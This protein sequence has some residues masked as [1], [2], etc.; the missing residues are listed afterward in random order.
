M[1]VVR[2]WNQTLPND[3]V[4][5][6][7]STKLRKANPLT[8]WCNRQQTH[9]QFGAIDRDH[10][11]WEITHIWN[12]KCNIFFVNW[13]VSRSPGLRLDQEIE[14]P[15]WE[16]IPAFWRMSQDRSWDQS[17]DGPQTRSWERY[18]GLFSGTLS[19]CNIQCACVMT[20]VL[21]V[22][23][24]SYYRVQVPPFSTADTADRVG[25]RNS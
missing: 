12:I 24:A 17:R 21:S 18:R 25:I 9:W 15:F 6:N 23:T 10:S 5:L 13:I 22:A 1:L 11:E 19:R 16:R 8:V 20:R 14:L 4:W 2:S 7:I 3:L